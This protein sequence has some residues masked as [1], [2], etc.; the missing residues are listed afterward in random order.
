MVFP[1]RVINSVSRPA[2]SHRSRIVLTRMAV[3][4]SFRVLP[5]RPSTVI[6]VY[7]TQDVLIV[8]IVAVRPTEWNADTTSFS[9]FDSKYPR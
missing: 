9:G 3:F 2:F 6:L 4:P 7:S 5:D 1:A 8:L